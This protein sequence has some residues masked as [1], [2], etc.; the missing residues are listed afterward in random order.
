[1]CNASFAWCVQ[2][3]CYTHHGSGSAGE[4]EEDFDAD[5][6]RQL[7]LPEHVQSELFDVQTV[8]LVRGVE[9][10]AV[11]DSDVFSACVGSRRDRLLH[12]LLIRVHDGLADEPHALADLS[13]V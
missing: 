9:L 3:L 7:L 13:F 2:T 8:I 12:L 5:V 6:A 1:M 4:A 10:P 11:A